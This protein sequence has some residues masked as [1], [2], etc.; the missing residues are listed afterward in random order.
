MAA[1]ARHQTP[2]CNSR[3]DMGPWRGSQSAKVHGT[4][5]GLADVEIASRSANYRKRG[6]CPQC[7][8]R[9]PKCSQTAIAACAHSRLPQ[10]AR[11][12]ALIE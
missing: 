2:L 1:T 6:E 11:A 8:L 4:H 10:D 12:D 7:R 9:V 3:F 5:S